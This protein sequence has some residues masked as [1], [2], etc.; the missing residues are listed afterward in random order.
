VS[1][2]VYEILNEQGK[3]VNTIIADSE[4]VEKRYKGFTGG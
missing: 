2:V 1:K 4:F 3:T